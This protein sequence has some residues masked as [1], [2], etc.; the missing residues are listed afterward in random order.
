MTIVPIP[1]FSDN[2]IWMLERE[3]RVAVVDPGDANPVLAVLQ[4]RGVILDTLIIT[5]HHFDHTGGVRAL[6]EKT[7]CRVVGPDNPKIEGI[8]EKLG[9]GDIVHVLGYDFAVLEVPGHTLDHIA[10]HCAD[11]S[12]L[13]CGDTLFVGGCGRVFEGTYPMM[14]SSLAKLASL[15]P[16]TAVYCTHEYTLANLAFA[17]KVEPD[18][19]DLLAHASKCERMRAENI[20]TVPSTIGRELEINPFLRWS[21]PAVIAQLTH[22]GRFEGG[23]PA[24]VFGAVRAWKDEG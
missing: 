1:A 3:G 11:E 19:E 6:K 2:Y 14:Q 4:E 13:F 24:E 7:N 22:E 16:E 17:R 15:P 10:L 21:S 9:D 20:P 12:V 18:N 5:H 23:S 8:D